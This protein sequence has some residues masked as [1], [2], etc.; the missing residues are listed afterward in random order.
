MSLHFW[1]IDA[2]DD[3]LKRHITFVLG[4]ISIPGK[5]TSSFR[6]GHEFSIY[7]IVLIRLFIYVTNKPLCKQC[8]YQAGIHHFLGN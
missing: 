5:K 6:F 7:V 2:V 4:I 8:I 1:S 3:V